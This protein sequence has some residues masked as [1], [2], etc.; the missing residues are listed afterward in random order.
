MTYIITG[1]GS[2]SD[3]GT[4][5]N[6]TELGWE[7]MVSRLAYLRDLRK[8]M[9][10]PEDTV[11]TVG[12]R[13]F[14][15]SKIAKNVIAFEDFKEENDVFKYTEDHV[16]KFEDLYEL[17]GE[18]IDNKIDHYKYIE[19][20]DDILNIDY[21]N[22]EEKYNISEKFAGALIR[23]RNWCPERNLK[24]QCYLSIIDRLKRKYKKVFVFGLE[25]ERFWKDKDVIYI[26]NLQ[27]WASIMHHPL[28][29]VIVASVSG[30]SVVCQI[31]C[32]SKLLLIQNTSYLLER[33][34]LFF[35]PNVTFSNLK[36]KLISQDVQSICNGINSL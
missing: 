22:V 25:S 27:D 2:K 36:I 29:D 34:P 15:Y 21:S 8:G 3:I 16:C 18:Y 33:H 13:K 17:H 10:T 6:Y 5:E 12:D 35:A 28:C 31:C 4:T 32:D 7:I 14:L 11:V 30:G 19:C 20:K 24:D 26:D 23:I 9:W 1:I